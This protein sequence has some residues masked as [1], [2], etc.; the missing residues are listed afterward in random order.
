M[1][2]TFPRLIQRILSTHSLSASNVY[3]NITHLE[4]N[5]RD[6]FYDVRGEFYYIKNVINVTLTL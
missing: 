4:T 3:I 6:T 5:T 2:I 1:V